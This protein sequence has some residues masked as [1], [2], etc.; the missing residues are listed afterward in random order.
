MEQGN[1]TNFGE[2]G[3]FKNIFRE[4]GN[5]TNYF[6]GIREHGPPLGGLFWLLRVELQFVIQSSLVKVSQIEWQCLT[7]TVILFHHD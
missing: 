3:N 5:M 2:H 4:Q 1:G 7:M 6:K